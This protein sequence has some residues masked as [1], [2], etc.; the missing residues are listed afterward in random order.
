MLI[1][2]VLFWLVFTTSANLGI[3]CSS[4]GFA[5][6]IFC[7]GAALLADPE[8]AKDMLWFFPFY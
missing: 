1:G 3:K 6:L 2:I 5:L 7:F 4:A 8:L